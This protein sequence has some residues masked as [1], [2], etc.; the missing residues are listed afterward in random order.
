[1]I[2]N[3]Y[4]SLTRLNCSVFDVD[5]HKKCYFSYTK[6]SISLEKGSPSYTKRSNYHFQSIYRWNPIST[7]LAEKQIYVTLCQWWRREG[8]E[9]LKVFGTLVTYANSFYAISNQSWGLNVEFWFT[10]QFEITSSHFIL[11]F[12]SR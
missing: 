6:K 4:H 11:T 12:F 3:L 9:K 1:M 8:R 2:T 7:V 10:V 5:S